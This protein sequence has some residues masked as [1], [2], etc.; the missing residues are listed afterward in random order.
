LNTDYIFRTKWISSI[1]I[2]KVM[3]RPK[4]I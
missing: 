1:V 4:F 2:Y 3:H